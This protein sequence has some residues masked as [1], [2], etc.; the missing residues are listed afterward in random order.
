MITHIICSPNGDRYFLAIRER[1]KKF[2]GNGTVWF[3][4]DVNRAAPYQASMWVSK[5]TARNFYEKVDSSQR[6]FFSNW[7]DA[8]QWAI[9]E[10]E[11]MRGGRQ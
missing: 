10:Y 4:P 11:R 9:S 8:E 7:L 6:Q 3:R 2:V 5:E 1:S